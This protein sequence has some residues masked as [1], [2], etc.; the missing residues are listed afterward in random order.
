MANRRQEERVQAALPVFFETVSGVTQDVSASG[1]FLEL[2]GV[3][4][5][6]FEVGRA[7]NFKVEFESPTGKMTLGCLGEVVWTEVREFST[8]IGLRIIDSSMG[9]LRDSG[10]GENILAAM[11]SA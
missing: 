5:G 10:S 8:R 6:A 4:A 1:M 9:M 2:N 7:V 11:P 3:H